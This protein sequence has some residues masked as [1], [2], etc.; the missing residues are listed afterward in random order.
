MKNRWRHQVAGYILL[1]L[2]LATTA[3]DSTRF[4][5]DSPRHRPDSAR[6]TSDTT[7]MRRG[8]GMAAIFSDSAKLTSSDYLLQIEKTYL[9]LNNIDNKSELGLAV[10][11][12]KERLT[13][14]D[15]VLAVLKENVLN[16]SHA[17]N[18]RNLQVFRSL[19]LNIQR[20]LK[21]HRALLD[22]TENKLSGLRSSMKTLVGDTVLRQLMRDSVLRKQFNTQLKDM[23]ET[24]RSSTR[25]LRASL[26]EINLL[27]THTSSNA[28]T[29]SQLLEKVNNLLNTS[30]ARI[31]GKEYNYLWEKDTDSISQ[32]AHSSLGKAYDGERKALHYYFKDSSNKRLFLLLIGLLFFTW[33]YRNIRALKKL[34]AMSAISNLGFEYLP[35]GFI[36]SSFV[37]MFCI[38]PLFDLHAP[39]AYIE[40]VQFLLLIILTI[41]C[42]KKWPRN[43]F[44][45]WI[46]MAILFLCFSFTHH[47]V[48]PGFWQRC[49]L[50]LLNILSIVFGLLFLSKMKEHLHLK[51]FLRFVIILH[52]VMNVL[53]VLFNI[54]GR[55]SL[56]QIFGNAAIFAFTQAIGLAVFSKICME[57]ILLQIMTSRVKRSVKSHFEYQ[58]VLDGFRRPVLFLVVVLWL[59]VFTTNLNIYTPV[60]HG[61]SVFLET[62]RYIGNANFTIGGVLLFF[63]IIW[64]AHLLQKYVGYFFGDTGTDDEIHNKGQRSR[65]LIARLILLCL[66][67]LLAVA[68]SG[69]PVD[70]ITIVLGALGVG[71]G[72]GLQNI[73]NNFVSG[74]ILIF[75]R[76]LQIGDS[77]EIGDKSGRVREIGLRSSTLLTQ[78]GAEVI[79]PNG[80]ILSQQ[81]TN[82]TLSNSQVRLEMELSVSGSPDMEVVSSAIKE[83][84]RTSKFVFESREPQI[85]F[86]KVNEDGFELKA[87]F[88]CADVFKS[89][90]A[91]SEVLILLH[92]KLKAANLRIN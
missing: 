56:A 83:A 81:I 23:R 1:L 78:D 61:L 15:S 45:S 16:N 89:G 86:T 52:N 36:V 70:K 41:I 29:T 53:S 11:E 6:Q 33:I 8:G 57:A 67:Y 91:K 65:L 21:E 50:I 18:L 27:Q 20:E 34:D 74:I 71:I 39:S 12:I 30:A 87:Y 28:I 75:D 85:L 40:S 9:I 3:Q 60:L 68:A 64:I 84:I 25:H 35:S 5:E 54:A 92:E 38:A 58:H 17:L 51:G 88:W 77:V 37:I 63:M 13:E 73:V 7:R 31:F 4:K 43:L 10:G 2:S 69:V 79:I 72:L 42:W 26:A 49:W 76:P 80:D 44:F 90:E 59:I 82:W 55:F 46:V 19:L 14:T 48:D 62:S 47:I 22:S 32:S 24:W 66:G